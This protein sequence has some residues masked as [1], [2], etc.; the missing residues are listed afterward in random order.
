[1]RRVLVKNG[2]ELKRR[3]AYEARA[4]TSYLILTTQYYLRIN[5]H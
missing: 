1:M 4:N 2:S 5:N 3:M